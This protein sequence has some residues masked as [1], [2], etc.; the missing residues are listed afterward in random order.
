GNLNLGGYVLGSMPPN[1][2]GA[3]LEPEE[4][5]VSAVT[6]APAALAGF[7]AQLTGNTA[8]FSAAQLTNQLLQLTVDPATGNL[9]HNRFSAGDPG[10]VSAAD[11]D[12]VVPGVQ[13]LAA[14]DSSFVI[15]SNGNGDSVRLGSADSPAS[16]L[17]AAITVSNSGPVGSLL[18]DDSVWPTAST[19]TV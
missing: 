10:F 3:T 6:S 17:K 19:Y 8:V 12:S 15:V 14:S 1:L 11:F 2:A 13:P 18:I 7:T 4:S 16:A 5:Q 9:M